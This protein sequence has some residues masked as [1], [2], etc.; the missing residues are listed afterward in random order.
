MTAQFT[1]KMLTDA[2]ACSKQVKLFRSLF[3]ESVNVTVARA[4]KV[5]DKFDWDFAAQFL[6]DEGRAEYQRVSGPAWAEFKRVSDAALA[7]YERVRDAAR[8]EYERVRDAARAEYERVSDAAWAEY[9][10]VR[11]AARA[12]YERVIDPA[13]AEYE[14]VIGPAWASAYIATCKRR[15]AGA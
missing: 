7:E 3:G 15:K 11:D 5:A 8:A 10:R 9:E 2:R 13:L 4:R 6:D 1:I 12:E 14:R